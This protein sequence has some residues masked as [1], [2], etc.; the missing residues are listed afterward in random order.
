M[1][2]AVAP[3]NRE[4]K[5]VKVLA[6]VKTKQHLENLGITIGTVLGVLVKRRRNR[7]RGIV[8]SCCDCA[9]CPHCAH[10]HDVQKKT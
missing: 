6:D 9:H 3:L 5:V 2:L 10:C 4:I 1:P 8:A 7:K